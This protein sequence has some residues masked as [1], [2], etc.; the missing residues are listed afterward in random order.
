MTGPQG[1][2]AAV[3]TG[4]WGPERHPRADAAR[5]RRADGADRGAPRTQYR[6]T[7]VRSRPGLA[8]RPRMEGLI[9]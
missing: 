4:D 5:L 9:T 1:H 3:R 7:P 2:P 8:A 6:G